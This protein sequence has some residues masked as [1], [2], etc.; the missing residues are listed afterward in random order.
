[1]QLLYYLNKL[2]RNITTKCKTEYDAPHGCVSVVSARNFRFGTVIQISVKCR[3]HIKIARLQV[4]HL[5][6][7]K[8]L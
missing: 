8:G 6:K 1:M 7:L 3:I 4:M 5:Q 2:N